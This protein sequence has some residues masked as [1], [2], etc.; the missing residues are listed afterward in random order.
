MNDSL[1]IKQR[2]RKEPTPTTPGLPPPA[3]PPVTEAPRPVKI[4]EKAEE[5]EEGEIAE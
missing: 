2:S 4:D 3:K 5:S 1:T